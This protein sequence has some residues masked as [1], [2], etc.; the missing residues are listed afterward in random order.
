M[1]IFDAFLLSIIQSFPSILTGVADLF[2]GLLRFQV[3]IDDILHQGFRFGAEE[4]A[5]SPRRH[6]IEDG[7]GGKRKSGRQ[8]SRFSTR[9]SA[10]GKKM[11]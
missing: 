7:E 11:A 6:C 8:R 4:L 2:G 1:I 5:N 3:K 10:C 9:R